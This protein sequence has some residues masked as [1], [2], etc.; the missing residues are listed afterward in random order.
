ML[1]LVRA[2]LGDRVLDYLFIDGD[3][4]YAG[5]KADFEQYGPLVKKGGLIAFHDIADGLPENVGGVPRFWNE[6]KH[7]FRNQE[8]IADP[9][10][11]GWGIGVLYVD[12]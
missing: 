5:V 12:R 2:T 11:G 9:K 3:H 6:L 8:F 10:Q 4:S 1:D 7:Q